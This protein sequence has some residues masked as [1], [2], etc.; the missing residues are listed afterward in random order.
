MIW[1]REVHG[2]EGQGRQGPPLSSEPGPAGA[3]VTPSPSSLLRFTASVTYSLRAHSFTRQMAPGTNLQKQL[4]YSCITVSV[5]SRGL[6]K[7]VEDLKP[8]PNPSGVEASKVGVTQGL[9]LR[10]PGW[11]HCHGGNAA[12]FALS[13]LSCCALNTTP[14]GAPGWLSRL[15]IRLS[16][17][18]QIMTPGS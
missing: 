12:L 16:I 11:F 2:N 14:R 10:G 6:Y 9:C 5:Y 13:P 7:E 17:W 8:P 1:R 3:A 15:S 18:A 4:S